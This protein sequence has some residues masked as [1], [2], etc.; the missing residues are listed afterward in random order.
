MLIPFT[1]G[2]YAMVGKKELYMYLSGSQKLIKRFPDMKHQTAD[3]VA[4]PTFVIKKEVF[5]KIKFES[6][7]TGED[8]SFVASTPWYNTIINQIHSDFGPAT[9]DVSN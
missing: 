7:N 6:R 3:F 4:G 5:D 1:F 8:S 2:D 9:S